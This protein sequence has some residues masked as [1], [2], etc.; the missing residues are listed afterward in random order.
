V[1]GSMYFRLKM[2]CER[3]GFSVSDSHFSDVFD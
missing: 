1:Y 3:I 2:P